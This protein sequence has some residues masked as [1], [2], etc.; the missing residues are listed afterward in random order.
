MTPDIARILEVVKKVNDE[1]LVRSWE[2][3]IVSPV[4]YFISTQCPVLD[5]AIGRPGIPCGRVTLIYGAEGCG[6]STLGTHLIASAQ[7]QGGLT[8]LIDTEYVFDP[9]RA[10]RIGVDYRSLVHLRTETMEETFEV[11][12]EIFRTVREDKSIP[13]ALVVWDSLAATPVASEMVKKDKFFDLQP[14]QQAK[15][16]S[17]SL[18]KLVK[19]IA[20]NHIALVLIN[21][22]REN[23]G[24]LYGP[25]EVMP[26]GRAIK[27]YSTL[28]L[29]L[30]GK[31]KLEEEGECIGIVCEA[32]VE[33][34]K[35]APPFQRVE[36]EISFRDGIRIPQ[37]YLSALLLVGAVKTSNGWWEVVDSRLP[38]IGKKFRASQWGEL[39]TPEM[40]KAS[41]ELLAAYL[42]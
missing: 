30:T 2:E 15:V 31:G 3:E 8:V 13:F 29:K 21:Q 14:G 9:E 19:D 5:L 7:S 36:F 38:G 12:Q 37:A 11:L 33:K 27:F 42:G 23:V 25:R 18:R 17:V 6:K 24:V 28:T 1:A 22:M 41:D 34:N 35:L 16:L 26:G 39:F 20:E 40:K 32:Y 4:K 10:E